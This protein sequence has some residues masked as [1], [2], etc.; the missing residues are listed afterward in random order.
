V[1]AGGPCAAGSLLIG[2]PILATLGDT[3]VVTLAGLV[4]NRRAV[5]NSRALSRDRQGRVLPRIPPG[6]Y[7]VRPGTVWV[8]SSYSPLSFDS[9]YFGAIPLANVRA[10]LG[11]T[12][13]TS[14]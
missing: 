12:V 9:R 10:G 8:V 14:R 7:L 2:R 3:A 4:V 13:F 1:P 6:A 5:P 11:P